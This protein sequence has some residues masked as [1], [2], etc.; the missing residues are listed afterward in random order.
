MKS[1]GCCCCDCGA[2]TTLRRPV[3]VTDARVFN[4]DVDGRDAAADAGGTAIRAALLLL[5]LLD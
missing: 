1:S 4:C 2:T 3:E 5:L